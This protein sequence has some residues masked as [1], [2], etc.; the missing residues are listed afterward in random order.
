MSD[1]IFTVET[2]GDA[3][4][5]DSIIDRSIT[6]LVDETCTV[7]G[8]FALAEADKLRKVR[9][10][11]VTQ[12]GADAFQ[13]CTSLE[14][15]SFPKITGLNSCSLNG[16]TNLTEIDM[17]LLSS[18]GKQYAF[19][20]AKALTRVDLPMLNHMGVGSHYDCAA[21]RNCSS[22]ETF[23]MRRNA[24]CILDNTSA[25]NG[26]P[27]RKGTGYVYVPAALIE[28]YQADQYW[29]QMNIQFRAIEDYPDICGT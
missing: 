13:G 19:E 15:I 21:F 22:L 29:S 7:V 18:I 11:N 23:I 16:L 17:P 20:D 5:C 2:V 1:V 14:S 6:E 28:A 25:L 26:T 10:E 4:L 3:A 8:Q 24:V 12:I 9:F 27:L